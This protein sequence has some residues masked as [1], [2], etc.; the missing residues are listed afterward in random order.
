MQ[1]T[2]SFNAAIKRHSNFNEDQNHQ[3]RSSVMTRVQRRCHF[4]SSKN[5]LLRDEN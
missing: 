1:T 3:F 2:N 4:F 5:K